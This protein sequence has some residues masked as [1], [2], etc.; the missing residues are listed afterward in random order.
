VALGFGIRVVI[1]N[2]PGAGG[3]SVPG[4]RGS[5]RNSSSSSW[6]ARAAT[7]KGPRG[8]QAARPPLARAVGDRPR[9]PAPNARTVRG[10][11]AARH[12]GR[13]VLEV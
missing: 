10:R 4:S 7:R 6:P 12:R 1:P 9:R 5:I 13:A 3:S 2:V 11:R 8:L